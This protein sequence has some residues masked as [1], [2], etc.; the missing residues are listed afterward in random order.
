M[1]TAMAV[2]AARAAGIEVDETA[3][4][5]TLGQIENEFRSQREIFLEGGDR[6][7]LVRRLF[8]SGEAGV[9]PQPATDSAAAAVMAKQTADG[10]WR[11]NVPISRA[12]MQEG[13]IA[14]TAEAVR[15]IGVYAPPALRARAADQIARA[16]AWLLQARARTT[17]DQAMLV[18]GIGSSQA[19]AADLRSH[20]RSLIALQRPDGGWGGNPNLP[21]DAF[22]TGEA[23]YA[24]SETGSVG[25]HDRVYQRGLDFL[26][27]TQDAS[28][29]WHVRSRAVKVM[30]YFDGGFP[31]GHDQWIS[32]AGT[33][34][35][36]VAL[37]RAL[38]R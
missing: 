12:P 28:G 9:P 20:A 32:A 23:L 3:A 2:G 27:R 24:L 31:F 1:A 14:L 25:V 7:V 35:A 33:A 22:S 16:R 21:S 19:S 37:S 36:D 34:W 11:R 5:D 10:S 38:T 6:E 13:I 4:R 17:D 26:L 30:P 15:A 18:L 29:A 8:A